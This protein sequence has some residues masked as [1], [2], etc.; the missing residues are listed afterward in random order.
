MRD[1]KYSLSK[2][3]AIEMLNGSLIKLVEDISRSFAEVKQT[4]GDELI[5]TDAALEQVSD[6]YG[7]VIDAKMDNLQV[8][9][10]MDKE[11]RDA[12]THSFKKAMS[13]VIHVYTGVQLMPEN[14]PNDPH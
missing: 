1:K 9:Q 5:I 13:K 2:S 6:F 3:E 7:L 4:L 8:E 11:D 12:M 14:G 10:K